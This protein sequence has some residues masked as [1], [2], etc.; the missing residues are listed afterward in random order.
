M[1]GTVLG[2]KT[3]NLNKE[4]ILSEGDAMAALVEL[5]EKVENWSQEVIWKKILADLWG[6]MSLMPILPWVF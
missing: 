1:E 4:K 5:K 6:K 2:F 3:S